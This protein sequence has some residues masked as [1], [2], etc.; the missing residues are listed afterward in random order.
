MKIRI[1]N[2]D[3]NEISEKEYL[4]I[5]YELEN[6]E[7][8]TYA[9]D[10]L[11]IV[12]RHKSTVKIVDNNVSNYIRRDDLRYEKPFFI[13][14][15]ILQVLDFEKLSGRH[16][17]NRSKLY[18]FFKNN[19][20]ELPEIYKRT[21]LNEEYKLNLIEGFLI[22]AN[23]YIYQKFDQNYWEELL[24]YKNSKFKELDEF[25]IKTQ[26][27][28]STNIKIE[29]LPI[30]DYKDLLIK[31]ISDTIFVINPNEEQSQ[32]YVNELFLLVD[33]LFLENPV[34]IYRYESYYADAIVLQNN[35]SY[36]YLNKI[37]I[38]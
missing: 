26:N 22:F 15:D 24:F 35:E 5:S 33:A 3:G 32:N 6:P 30:S 23:W 13:L 9:D 19:H 12:S 14:E 27:E 16:I 21:A 38:S 37:W 20:Y 25:K 8:L 28:E 1:L 36:Y 29:E 7:Y 2:N 31:F 34:S 10:D 4:V 18:L 11:Y 17:W